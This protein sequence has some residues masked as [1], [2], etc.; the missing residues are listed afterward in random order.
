MLRLPHRPLPEPAASELARYQAEVDG[1]RAYKTQVAEAKRLFGQRN[2][3]GNATFDAVK[4]ELDAM[5]SGARR[6]GYCEDSAADEVEHILAKDWFPER[7]FV[8]DNY[9]YACGPCNGPKGNAYG[10]VTGQPATLT[11]ATRR[12]GER[13][14]RPPAGPAALID[15]RYEDPLD[16]FTLDLTGTFWFVARGPKGTAARERADYTL[17]VLRLNTRDVLTRARSHAFDDFSAH[18]EAYATS[19]TNGVSEEELE[20]RRQRIVGRQHPTV[21]REMQRQH[22]KH[23]SLTLLFAAAPEALTW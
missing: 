18:L 9:L 7:A 11:E 5:C 15:P 13:L 19:K 22:D 4:A 6:C 16:F 12:P 8:W 23:R 17:R 3:N 20:R 10:V 14:M 21:W 2:T 1:H